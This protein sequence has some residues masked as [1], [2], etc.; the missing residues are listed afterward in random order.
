MQTGCHEFRRQ[1]HLHR[2]DLLKVGGAG[3]FGLSWP[4]LFKA[5]EARAAHTDG[6]TLGEPKAKQMVIVWCS[7]GLSHHDSFDMKPDAPEE[8][9]GPWQ[10]AHTNV[11]GLQISELMPSLA[12]V[13]DKFTVVR[14]CNAKGYPQEGQHGIPAAWAFLTG[15]RRDT[16]RRKPNSPQ[17]PLYGSVMAKFRPGPGDVPHYVTVSSSRSHESMLGP[18]FDPMEIK[19]DDPNDKL[20]RMLAP[21]AD[22]LDVPTLSR[23]AEL[24]KSVDRQLRRFDAAEPLIAGM[25]KF[26]QRA[27]DLLRSPKLREALDIDREEPKSAERYKYDKNSKRVLAARRLIEAGVPCVHVDFNGGWDWHGG[28]NLKRGGNDLTSLAG[29]VAALIEDLDARGLLESTIVMV[30]S[31]MGHT[32][33]INRPGFGREHWNDAQS[34]LLAG[35]GFAGGC[36]VGATDDIGAFVTKD[37]YNASSLARTIYNRLGIDPDHEIYTED[38]RPVKI[39]PDDAALIKE[40]MA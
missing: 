11:P 28:N 37:Y 40:A 36:V 17:S 30:G 9:R 10:P 21:P 38:R 13:A 29:S 12:Q 1:Y 23:R 2:R 33:K 6:T 4:V 26:K 14:S 18:A 19:V 7:G 15:T 27:F 25:D 31:E 16:L 8:I 22:R 24:L 35:G 32:P 5:Q 20:V 39:V 34:F 3:L